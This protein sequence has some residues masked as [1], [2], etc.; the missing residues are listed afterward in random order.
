MRTVVLILTLVAMAP[1]ALIIMI[2]TSAIF[3]IDLAAG[4]LIGEVKRED[5]K[6]TVELSTE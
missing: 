2:C 6:I 4:L 5:N 1:F 3:A